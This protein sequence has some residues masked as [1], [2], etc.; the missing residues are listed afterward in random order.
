MYCSDRCCY[1]GLNIQARLDEMKI[2]LQLH[3]CATA[4]LLNCGIKHRSHRLVDRGGGGGGLGLFQAN[5]DQVTWWKSRF[6]WIYDWLDLMFK[7]YCM[8]TT[9]SNCG[10]KWTKCTRAATGRCQG[11]EPDHLVCSKISLSLCKNVSE[12]L[13][14]ETSYPHPTRASP[15]VSCVHCPFWSPW[16]Y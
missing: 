8:L 13:G 9:V 4:R 10:G 1:A 5:W 14:K 12:R 2:L 16:L 11:T 6:V 15:A 3:L 7:L